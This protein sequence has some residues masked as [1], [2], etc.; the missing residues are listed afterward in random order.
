MA[1]RHVQ[2]VGTTITTRKRAWK[3]L[4]RILR[5]DCLDFIFR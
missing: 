4:G 3:V 1:E 2:G 5:Q